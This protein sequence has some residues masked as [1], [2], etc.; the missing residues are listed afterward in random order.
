MEVK[1]VLD[2][3]MVALESSDKITLMLDLTAS[4]NP[5]A[6]NRPGQAV[7][8]VLD[9]SG[10]MDGAPLDA[11][12]GSLLKLIER[13]AP[14]DLFGLVAFDDNAYVVAPTRTMAD[15]D[16][17]VLRMVISQMETGGSTDISAGYL[18]GLRDLNRVGDGFCARA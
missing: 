15:H 16:M 4:A 1:A 18:L 5:L 8:I 10:S 6:A 17:Q 2:V 14:Q 11:A 12:K 13:L 7:Q 9:R 3:D